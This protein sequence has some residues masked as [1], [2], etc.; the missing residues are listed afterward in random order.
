[1]DEA[2]AGLCIEPENEE[3]LLQAMERLSTE[4]GLAKKLGDSGYR[5]IALRYAYDALAVSY[6]EVLAR[7][8]TG[9]RK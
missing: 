4:P 6:L 5:Q 8:T 9:D 7:E 2:G 3:H 1:M